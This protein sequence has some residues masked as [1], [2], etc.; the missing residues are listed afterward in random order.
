METTI[1]KTV[2][3]A[4]RV[5]ANRR[6]PESPIAIRQYRH[7]AAAEPAIKSAE[8]RRREA[9]ALDNPPVKQSRRAINEQAREDDVRQEVGALGDPPEPDDSANHER[10]RGPGAPQSS[11][12]QQK[13]EGDEREAKRGVTRNKSAIGRALAGG[14]RR[15]RKF[16]RSA[17]GLNLRRTRATPMVLQQRVREEPGAQ[18]GRHD[19]KDQRFAVERPKRPP[20]KEKP[21]S[22]RCSNG[23]DAPGDPWH[24]AMEE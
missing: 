1:A 18:C 17:K 21:E 24:R 11:A 22:G 10:H 9:V 6:F 8:Q 5:G 4:A 15:R 16:A 20:Q 23:E 3:A 13:G 12:R 2:A 14:Q 7:G 19:E